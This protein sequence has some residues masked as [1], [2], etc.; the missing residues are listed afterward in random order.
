MVALTFDDGPDPASTPAVLDVLDQFG[1]VATFFMIGRNVVERPD[2]AV[3][4]LRRGH[5]VASH[6]QDHLW[7]DEQPAAV[8]RSQVLAGAA[9][10]ARVGAPSTR[11]FRPPH[12]WTS[13][14]VAR[15]THAHGLR[16]IFW[17]ECLEHYLRLGDPSS[18]AAAVAARTGPGSII[19]C[20][21]GGHLDGPHPQSLDRAAT[22]AAL[23]HM[24]DAVLS[25]DL[26]FA[27]VS[28]LTGV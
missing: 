22:V 25:K 17:S 15:V 7:L 13:P 16:C 28:E 9:S 3:E 21:D 4:V 8:V 6:T 20:H 19:L 11:L 14:T 27:T 10:L 1:V 12:G 26:R 24:L 18:A 23:P 5:Q 2:L